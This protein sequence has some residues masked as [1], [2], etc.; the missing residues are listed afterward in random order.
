MADD[1]SPKSRGIRVIGADFQI[2]GLS[3]NFTDG[4][5]GEVTTKLRTDMWSFWLEDAIDAAEAAYQFADQIPPLVNQLDDAGDGKEQIETE[6]DRVMIREMRTTMRAI[7]ASAFA[8]DAFYAMVK[9]RCGPHPDEDVWRAKGTSRKRRITETL[10]YHLRIKTKSETQSLKSCVAQVFSFRD[11]AVHMVSEF[12]EPVYRPDVQAGVDWHFSVFRRDNAV[13]AVQ[14]T[15][16]VLHHLVSILDQ[17]GDELA[18]CKPMALQRMES[19][20]DAY[21]KS[22]VLPLLSDAAAEPQS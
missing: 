9:A 8:I 21:K 14:F 1:E 12:L 11:K 16:L 17:G 19:V 5:M 2:S 22:D 13:A 3:I 6:I 18:K 7:T 4:T 10:R 15:I 20:V